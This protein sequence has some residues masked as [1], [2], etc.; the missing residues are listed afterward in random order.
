MA[1]ATGVQK[2]CSYSKES[3]WGVAPAAGT[4]K[5]L[6]RTTLELDLSRDSF[7]SAE[8]SSTAQTSDMRLGSDNV[9]GTLS[10][11]L[12]PG[13]YSDFFAS[14]LR[15]TW[16][17]A[18]TTT[19]VTIAADATGNK[20]VRSAGSWIT[21]GFKIGDLVNISGFTTT[22]NNGSGVII[23]LT[24]F[25]MSLDTSSITLV[26]EVEGDSVT[27]ATAG[28][29][30]IVP[31]LP[32]SRT[33]ES[34]TI[35]QFYDNI[36]V[37]RLATGVKIGSATVTIA[38]NAMTTVE[39]GLLGKNVASTSAQYFTN[40]AA[41]STTSIFSG[42]AGLLIVDGVAQAVVTGL[43]FEITGNQEAGTVIGQRNPAAIFL[44]RITCTGEFTA[45]FTDDTLFDKFYD[46]QEISLVYKFVGDEGQTMIVK[47]PRIKVG[48]ATPDDKEVG[49]ILQTV[50]FTALL[51]DGT[52]T[53]VEQSTVVFID[54]EVA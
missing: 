38:P 43:N 41:A 18:T 20:L 9:E 52:D 45:Y 11:E 47:F 49:G 19:A 51:N 22:A 27:V 42:N 24:A 40:P 48:G 39:F 16:A 25:E 31:I 35:E 7:E 8:I 30:L 44:G 32:A 29:K 50:P 3:S 54:S 53:T 4:G 1:I 36:S 23:T 6:R 33:D 37:S 10:G 13:S 46:E 17:A 2:L 21:D 34:Y 28:K 14:L 26:T 5:Y 15:G 12:S